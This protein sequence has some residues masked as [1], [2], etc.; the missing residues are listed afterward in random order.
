MPID[1]TQSK[2]AAAEMLDAI[3]M[4]VVH[5]LLRAKNH[6]DRGSGI[7]EQLRSQDNLPLSFELYMTANK[8]YNGAYGW[9]RNAMPDEVAE[10]AL[11]GFTNKPDDLGRDWGLEAN[12]LATNA[13]RALGVLRPDHPFDV[14]HRGQRLPGE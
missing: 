6:E 2:L 14:F 13:E 1:A 10:K 12:W 3:C 9:L 11:K 5:T 8:L 4:T 7:A